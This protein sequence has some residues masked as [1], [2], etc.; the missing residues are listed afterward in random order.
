MAVVPAAE[1]QQQRLIVRDKFGLSH[2]GL[3]CSILGCNVSLNLGDPVH[4]LFLVTPNQGI[5]LNF[6]LSTLLQQLGILDAEVDQTIALISPTLTAIPNGLYDAW[7]DYYYGSYVWNGY[8]NQ[9]ASGIVGIS[10]TQEMFNVSGTG[11][12]AVIDTGLD[13]RHP[14]LAQVVLP[15]YD[16]TRNS[17]GADETGDLDH[18]TAGVLDGG[19]G[20]ALYVTPWLAAVVPPAGAA[21]LNNPA[22]S[23]FGHGTMTAGLVHLVAP[24]A[25]ILPLK[26]FGANGSGYA[27]D[28]IRALYY[29]AAQGANVVSMSFSFSALPST[30]MLK[31]V[32]YLT[33]QG[34]TCVAAAGND[35][36]KISVYPASYTGVIGVASTSDNDTRSSFSNYGSQ[37]VWVAAPGEGVVSS[38]PFGTYASASGTSFSTPLVAGTVALLNNF[39][40]GLNPAAIKNAVGNAVYLTQDL[41]RGRLDTTLALGSVGH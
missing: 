27:S 21:A 25:K 40:Q 35:G 5:G 37:V 36:K 26:A 30:E 2:L 15:G 23:A 13:P 4:Q 9:P 20:I 19:P 18:S 7:P 17:A 29:A 33:A 10:S 38:F 24:T 16:F 3:L 39:N 32:N 22:Y 11:I 28:V 8:L 6:L 31:A 34:L 12:V 1:A 41:N 14:A